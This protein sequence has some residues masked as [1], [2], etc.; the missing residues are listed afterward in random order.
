MKKGL[1]KTAQLLH[2]EAELPTFNA[3]RTI[4]SLWQTTPVSHNRVGEYLNFN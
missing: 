4:N 1:S 3:N 2:N